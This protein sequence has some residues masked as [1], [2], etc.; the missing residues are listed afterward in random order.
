[1]ADGAEFDARPGGRQP[2]AHGHDA[3]VVG[4]EAV[5]WWIWYGAATKTA[6]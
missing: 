5:W 1:M 4:D 6:E 2:R 3:W